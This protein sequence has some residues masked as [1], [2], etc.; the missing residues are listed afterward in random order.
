[1]CGGFVSVLRGPAVQLQ[2]LGATACVLVV[3]TAFPLVLRFSTCGHCGVGAVVEVLLKS[4]TPDLTR[5]AFTIRL[6]DCSSFFVTAG[7]VFVHL[8]RTPWLVGTLGGCPFLGVPGIVSHALASCHV[9]HLMLIC[10][11]HRVSLLHGKM[12][13]AEKNKRLSEFSEA[14]KGKGLRV[15]VSTSIIEVMRSSMR[16][17]GD[18][19][20]TDGGCD[21]AAR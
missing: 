11:A 1:M 2:R 8:D 5:T 12:S 21:E 15:L 9:P 18:L 4:H 3:L 10:L 7:L 6:F 16:G 14:E 20:S 13:S 17:V 19:S